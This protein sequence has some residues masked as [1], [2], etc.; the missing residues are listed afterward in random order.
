MTAETRT[1]PQCGRKFTPKRPHHEYDSEEC[2]Y[3]G[4]IEKQINAAQAPVQRV[5]GHPLVEV[6]VNQATKKHN[7]DL[8]GLIRQAIVDQIKTK[9]ECFA[10]DLVDL[11]PEGEVKEC[12]R[13]ATAQ[14]GS[15]TGSGLIREKERR[16]ST[17]PARKGAKS[18]VYIFTQ[19]GR[20]TL[21]GNAAGGGLS[22][23]E[24]ASGVSGESTGTDVPGR[25]SEGD[26]GGVASS[27][28]PA[29]VAEDVE[30]VTS[31]SAPARLFEDQA[32]SAYDRL[33]DVA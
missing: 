8:G 5:E 29:S 7:R 14:F 2:R 11:Y 22:F 23:H 10:D 15:L 12:R 3:Q 18:G 30:A 25:Q 13:L 4:W 33:R 1:C 20:E 27:S 31:T 17:I 16:K 26:Q 32:P 24:G 21:V 9:G 6:R 19:K 28:S